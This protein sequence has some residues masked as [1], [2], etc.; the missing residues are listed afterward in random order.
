MLICF[1]I[2]PHVSMFPTACP[3]Y[4]NMLI[5]IVSTSILRV[6]SAAIKLK[7]LVS[8]KDSHFIEINGMQPICRCAS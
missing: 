6:T 1:A 8:E 4:C 5:I 2:A 3:P 7:C